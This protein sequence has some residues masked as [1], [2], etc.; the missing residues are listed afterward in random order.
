MAVY[1]YKTKSGDKYMYKVCVNYHQYLKRG[2]LTKEEATRAMHLFLSTNSFGKVVQIPKFY[3]LYES[4][5]VFYKD[6]VKPSTYVGAYRQCKNLI[7]DFMPNVRIDKLVY[8]DFTNWKNNLKVYSHSSILKAYNFMKMIFDYCFNFYGYKCRTF[9]LVPK[10]KDYSVH[11]N[12]PKNK[13]VSLEDFQKFLK[14]LPSNKYY[15]LFVLTYIT[16][17]RIG[18]VRG[19]TVDSFQTDSLFIYQQVNSRLNVGKSVVTSLKTDNSKRVVKLPL[20]LFN[21][22]SKYIK[23]SKLKDKNFLFPSSKNNNDPIGETTLNKVLK[24]TCMSAGIENFHFH[25]LRHTQATL[26]VDS[27]FDHKIVADYLGHSSEK[28]TEKFYLHQDETDA[29]KI[30]ELLDKKFKDVF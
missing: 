22:I 21:L 13:V 26:L 12:I 2:F 25:M 5:F 4:F 23:S 7:R 27:G 19:L 18:E 9:E 3:D 14:V 17:L 30:S 29:I 16:G 1:K 8:S 6:S 24:E 20:F 28:V 11:S 10:Y 15:V